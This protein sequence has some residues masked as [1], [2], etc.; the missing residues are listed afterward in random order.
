[1]TFLEYYLLSTAISLTLWITF[2]VLYRRFG[3]CSEVISEKEED[4]NTNLLAY[5]FVSFVPILNNVII[6][7]CIL[8][9]SISYIATFVYTVILDAGVLNMSNVCFKF[10]K[11]AIARMEEKRRRREKQCCEKKRENQI[12]E[13]VKYK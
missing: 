6:V 7:F 13:M 1:M 10:T 3:L 2:V 11:E 5:F 9:L 12:I 4:Y 8:L